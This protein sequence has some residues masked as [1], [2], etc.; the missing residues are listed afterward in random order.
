MGYA[1]TADMLA[2]YRF[3][4]LVERTNIADDTADTV[5]LP[6]LQQA[7]DDASGEIDSYLIGRYELPL[8]STPPLLNRLCRVIARKNLYHDAPPSAGDAD[9]WRKEYQDAVELLTKITKGLLGI[10]MNVQAIRSGTALIGSDPQ[11]F[12]H[13]ANQQW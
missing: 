3:Q 12:S 13:F 5:N 7:L 8:A 10:D 9:Q 1:G 11:V 4:E 2:A 6:V